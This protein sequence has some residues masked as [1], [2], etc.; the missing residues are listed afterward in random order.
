MN[1]TEA[2][3]FIKKIQS[4]CEAINPTAIKLMAPNANNPYTKG[5]QISIN[6]FFDSDWIERIKEIAKK[7]GLAVD[8]KNG[9]VIIY[10]PKN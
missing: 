10:K 4:I 9:E 1:R 2:I 8:V 3:L 6:G 5:Y 7:D